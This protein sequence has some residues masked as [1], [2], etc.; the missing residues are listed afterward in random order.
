[1]SRRD[2]STLSHLAYSDKMY[3]TR[4]KLFFFLQKSV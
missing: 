1:M 3:L 2:S 4:H